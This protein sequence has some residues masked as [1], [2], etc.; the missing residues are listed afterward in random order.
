MLGFSRVFAARCGRAWRMFLCEQ[1]Q[2][3]VFACFRS[4]SIPRA[5]HRDVARLLSDLN[6]KQFHTIVVY[7]YSYS[8][9][10]AAICSRDC[11]F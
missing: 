1:L 11:S 5:A 6:L 2:T 8:C 9:I 3:L 7:E 10:P 4:S